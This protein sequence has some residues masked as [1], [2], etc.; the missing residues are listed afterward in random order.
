MI[1]LPLLAFA[2]FI[3]QGTACLL[4]LTVADPQAEKGEHSEQY[5]LTPA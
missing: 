4:K 2:R 1:G 5:S 3:E